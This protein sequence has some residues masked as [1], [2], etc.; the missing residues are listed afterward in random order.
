MFLA[1]SLLQSVGLDQAGLLQGLLLSGI[2]DQRSLV[3]RLKGTAPLQEQANGAAVLAGFDFYRGGHGC[4]LLETHI[5]SKPL[6]DT[7]RPAQT[8]RP[9][10]TPPSP[11]HCR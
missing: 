9:T 7:P 10:R 1:C 8:P 2:H 4:S 11:P 6:S 5:P 3:S